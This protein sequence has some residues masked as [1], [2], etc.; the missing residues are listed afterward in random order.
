MAVGEEEGVG[1]RERWNCWND[2]YV[3]D[4]GAGRGSLELV[5]VSF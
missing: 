4:E 2:G 3:G 5:A 1:G